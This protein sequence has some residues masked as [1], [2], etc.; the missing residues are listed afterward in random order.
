MVAI[1]S[2]PQCIKC[3]FIT[4]MMFVSHI[5]VLLSFRNNHLYIVY[6]YANTPT[7]L[8]DTNRSIPQ[9]PQRASPGLYPTIHNIGSLEDMG[10][11]HCGICEMDI[12]IYI[13]VY[14]TWH[15][16]LDGNVVTIWH[17][18]LSYLKYSYCDNSFVSKQINYLPLS[19]LSVVETP[20][21]S[22]TPIIW[23]SLW[24]FS[25]YAPN[26]MFQKETKSCDIQ[27][28]LSV[29]GWD[30]AQETREVTYATLL[31]TEAL[32]NHA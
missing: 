12:Y 21:F 27:D 25:Q 29:Y 16:K 14:S 4:L 9:I 5:I 15:V 7:C 2:R 20:M 11:V 28:M 30:L 1:L 17:F 19:K 24:V 3:R 32:L 10:Q 6:Q 13:C 31:S 22:N 8:V 18:V 23:H 26:G